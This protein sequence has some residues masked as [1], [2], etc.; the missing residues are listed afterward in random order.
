M[1]L[2][3]VIAPEDKN[4]PEVYEKHYVNTQYKLSENTFIPL[5]ED[6]LIYYSEND[7]YCNVIKNYDP[8]NGELIFENE[9]W[10][11]PEEAEKYFQKK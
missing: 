6:T 7:I 8:E 5:H 1:E 2:R 9:D 3:I 4:V 10:M 11:T